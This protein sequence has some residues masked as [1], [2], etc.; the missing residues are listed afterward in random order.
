MTT[1]TLP[2]SVIRRGAA[3]CLHSDA[4]QTQCARDEHVRVLGNSLRRSGVSA[5][6]A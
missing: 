2:A 4:T 6:E 3:K 5:I 1:I